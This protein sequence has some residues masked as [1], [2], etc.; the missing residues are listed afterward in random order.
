MVVGIVALPSLGIHRLLQKREQSKQLKQYETDPCA[1]MAKVT[2]VS[3]EQLVKSKQ[4]GVIVEQQCGRLREA[5][6]R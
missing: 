6:K 1:Y 5:F 2:Q 4:L 3:L